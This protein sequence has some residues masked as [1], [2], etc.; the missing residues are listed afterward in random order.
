MTSTNLIYHHRIYFRFS[1]LHIYVAFLRKL[2]QSYLNLCHYLL[3]LPV[4]VNLLTL[5]QC[6]PYFRQNT[7]PAQA[8]LLPS[9]CLP[10]L[11]L[12]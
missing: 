3:T 12:P 8:S 11:G 10:C 5:L 2:T 1:F 7:I 6:C 4:V 9:A